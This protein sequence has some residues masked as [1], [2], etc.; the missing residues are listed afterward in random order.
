MA[1]AI[2]PVSS[3]SFSGSMLSM[4]RGSV[5]SFRPAVHFSW[6]H[7]LQQPSAFN[8]AR[9]F[10]NEPLVHDSRAKTSITSE[11]TALASIGPR[12]EVEFNKAS[13]GNYS[14]EAE[15][16]RVFLRD[17]YCYHLILF[18]MLSKTGIKYRFYSCPE[19]YLQHIYQ[20]SFVSR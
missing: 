17:E 2:S 3:V 14:T 6:P 13:E 9:D 15:V 4:S 7:Q 19:K 18:W 1:A 11:K 8:Q 12:P 20:I 5:A 16:S 10:C